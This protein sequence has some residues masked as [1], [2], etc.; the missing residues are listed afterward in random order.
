MSYKI[1]LLG[2]SGTGK[3]C[4]SQRL[5]KDIYAETQSTIGAAFNIMRYNNKR[6][7]I[8]DTGGQERYLA[9]VSTYYRNADIYLLVCDITNDASIR[10]LDYF[11]DKITNDIEIPGTCIIL[12]NKYDCS[13]VDN[14]ARAEKIIHTLTDKYKNNIVCEHMFI[15][16]KTGYGIMELKQK[17]DEYTLTHKSHHVHSDQIIITPSK[18]SYCCY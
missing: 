1:V 3:T 13:D 2:V 15:S 18:Q 6:Y 8:W 4:L 9:L 11:L 10:R 7:E 17:F 12:V 5:T 16:N 14:I